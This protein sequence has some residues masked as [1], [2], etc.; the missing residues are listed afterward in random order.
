MLG[1][2]R[3]LDKIV[4]EQLYPAATTRGGLR[5][6]RRADG[7][8][9]LDLR[10]A[11]SH[12]QSDLWRRGDPPPPAATAASSTTSSIGSGALPAASG[13]SGVD[14]CIGTP[15]GMSL[16]SAS[17]P[18]KKKMSASAATTT[19]RGAPQLQKTHLRLRWPPA[20]ALR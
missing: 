13:T 8:C 15:A 3:R 14:F 4:R 18:V 11:D 5:H 7:L 20:T 10:G 19:P 2:R 1:H 17:A 9:V 16:S 12:L 6:Q